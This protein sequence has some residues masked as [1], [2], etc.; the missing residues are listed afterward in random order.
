MNV[1]VR[2]TRKQAKCHYEPCSK[3]I[4][5]GRYQVVCQWYMPTPSGKR[6]KKQMLFHP[7]C[8]LERAIIEIEK[9][10]VVET[11]GRKRMAIT[12]TNRKKRSSILCR[13]ASV[14]QRIRTEMDKEVR[15]FNRIAHLGEL[16]EKLKA[17]IEPYGGAPKSW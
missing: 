11:R 14:L 5:N 6:W 7:Q 16:L 15:N 13:R 17:E 3:P 4:E 2:K 9:R 12:D 8:W 10:T 1:W